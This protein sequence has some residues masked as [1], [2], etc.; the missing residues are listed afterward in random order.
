M[1]I[2]DL[3]DYIGFGIAGN[4]AHHL[5]QAG[6]AKDFIDVIVDEDNAPKGI[7]PFYAKGTN[8]FLNTFPLSHDTISIPSDISYKVQV[9]PEVALVCEIIY[10]NDK[11]IDLKI[12]KFTAYNDCSI[13]EP[14]APKISQK[15]NWGKNTKGISLDF[16]NIDKFELNGIMDDYA[17]SSFLKDKDG[18]HEYGKDSNI[19]TYSYFH[20][21]LKNWII[22]KL[23]TQEDFGPL[24]NLGN[25]IKE[26]NYPRNMIIAIG[27]TQY[28]EFGEHRFLQ[29]EDEIYICLYNKNKYT[30]EEIKNNIKNNYK[31]LDD[32]SILHQIVI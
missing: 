24:E 32:T 7:F 15:K 10:K 20:T 12:N 25:I 8:S 29:K 17:I 2:N 28:T 18:F 23:N 21:K 13:R 4:F 19:N 22:N 16:I 31:K 1:D 27:A 30:Y 14:G 6:E 26:N 5:D 11:V 3:K 9:E